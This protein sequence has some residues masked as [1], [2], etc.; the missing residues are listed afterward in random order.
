MDAGIIIAL[1]AGVCAGTAIGVRPLTVR[2]TGGVARRDGTG[3]PCRDPPGRAHP[4]E[5]A[6]L[7]G[8]PGREHV[9]LGEVALMELFLT[10]RIRAQTEMEARGN[11]GSGAP[12]GASLTLV[13]GDAGSPRP[14]DPD[15]IQHHLLSLIRS[16]TG[17]PALFLVDDVPGAE[18]DGVRRGLVD[19]GLSTRSAAFAGLLHRRKDASG[20]ALATLLGSVALTT[21]L[22]FTASTGDGPGAA[23]WWIVLVLSA[24]ATAV[25]LSLTA[26]GRVGEAGG[27]A[28]TPV[29]AAGA[30]LLA[31]AREPYGVP[32]PG[33]GRVT[34]SQAL[35]HTA[36]LGFRDL[37]RVPGRESV[38]C[39]PS[40][41]TDG[42]QGSER[43]HG[44][45]E[46]SAFARRCQGGSLG[47]DWNHG[48]S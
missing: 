2:L 36:V 8:E 15:P 22:L 10:G 34:L 3:A 11:R 28:V 48:S 32:P 38:L 4:Y 18:A 47:W 29:T 35:R 30:S 43:T 16:H 26:L 33:A 5:L 17:M 13:G 46:L 40:V 14:G 27:A 12:D 6:Y 9:R 21:V 7:A 25:L 41:R 37:Q 45:E 20:S 19:R 24:G 44:F 42:A 31:G 39:A 23:D 1:V